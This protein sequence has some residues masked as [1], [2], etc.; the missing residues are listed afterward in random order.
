MSEKCWFC[1]R[2]REALLRDLPDG[3]WDDG[4]G[5]FREVEVIGKVCNVD[6]VRA[7][8]PRH[9][10][11]FKRT[12][13]K[14]DETCSFD[15]ERWAVVYRK[16]QTIKVCKICLALDAL[17]EL[18]PE[19]SKEAAVPYHRIYNQRSDDLVVAR[20]WERIRSEE[21][22]LAAEYPD[23]AYRILVDLKKLDPRVPISLWD[24]SERIGTF[25]HRSLETPVRHILAQCPELGELRRPELKIYFN[26]PK[27]AAE[28]ISELLAEY[29]EYYNRDIEE[30]NA[31][32]P[33]TET[34]ARVKKVDLMPGR[35]P[36]ISRLR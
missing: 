30:K 21:R 24:I 27:E 34:F 10:H 7:G 2:D 6:R 31:A 9:N 15:G 35:V 19:E 32:V 23:E 12:E 29:E 26:D 3:F 22:E 5:I 13:N 20:T 8:D 33:P 16:C 28:Q 1:G 11:H 4:I 25:N 14:K 17:I 36:G 18:L